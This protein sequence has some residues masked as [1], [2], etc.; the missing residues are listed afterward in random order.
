MNLVK[1]RI[2]RRRLLLLLVSNVSQ[3]IALCSQR[4]GFIPTLCNRVFSTVPNDKTLIM[5]SKEKKENIRLGKQTASVYAAKI[6]TK[7]HSKK[8]SEL[9]NRFSCLQDLCSYWLVIMILFFRYLIILQALFEK[10]Q[11]GS[12]SGSGCSEEEEQRAGGRGGAA[13]ERCAD[14]SFWSCSSAS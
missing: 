4:Q 9:P 7:I 5:S 6:K 2:C 14:L 8:Y 1:P 13:D 11:Q 3:N 12:G 10:Q